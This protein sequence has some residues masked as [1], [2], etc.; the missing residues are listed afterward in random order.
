MESDRKTAICWSRQNHSQCQHNQR[1]QIMNKALLFASLA[2]LGSLTAVGTATAQVA[3]ST[4]TFGV[5]ITEA[6]EVARGWSVKKGILGKTV[7]DDAGNKI[8]SV[9]DLIITPENHVSYVIVGAGGFIGMG[10]HDVAIPIAQIH[11]VGS[12]I[13]MPGATK[14]IVKGMPSFSYAKDTTKRD[15]FMRKV[16]ENIAKAKNEIAALETKAA[17]IT[18]DARTKLDADNIALKKDLTEAEEKLA[19]LK[20]AVGEEWLTFEAEVNAAIT[21]L[22]K[23]LNRTTVSA[24]RHLDNASDQHNGRSPASGQ[25]VRRRLNSI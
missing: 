22:R 6:S 16:D 14:E 19:K 17:T 12:K 11:E 8:G 3:G 7:Y 13:V 20:R 25:D 18:G 21:R 4:T 5:T 24:P 1:I 15:Q 2:I 23:S 9:Q 10:R